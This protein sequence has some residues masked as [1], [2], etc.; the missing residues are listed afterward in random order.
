MNI[1]L[2]YTKEEPR[3]KRF[4]SFFPSLFHFNEKYN[5]RTKTIRV[6]HRPRLIFG[7]PLVAH[8]LFYLT[9]QCCNS[10]KISTE[11]GIQKN[12]EN[13]VGYFFETNSENWTDNISMISGYSE[14][15]SVYHDYE[16]KARLRIVREIWLKY[17]QPLW[18]VMWEAILKKFLK[19]HRKANVIETLF[20]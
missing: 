16:F 10:C 12:K 1:Y 7:L 11:K 20:H 17:K 15:P 14:L 9:T 13:S 8:L 18:R 3:R 2:R 5:P 19:T 4:C 6:F